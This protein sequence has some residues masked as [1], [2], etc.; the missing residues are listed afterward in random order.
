MASVD[1]KLDSEPTLNHRFLKQREALLNKK[2]ETPGLRMSKGLK[3]HLTMQEETV[4]GLRGPKAKF[5]EL[6][7]YEEKFGPAP[8]EKIK[9][10]TY[11]GA[12]IRGVDVIDDKVRLVFC[13]LFF[14]F[15]QI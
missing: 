15:S 3:E 10:I 5:M 8:P 1:K 6:S 9:T 12:S 13:F 11:K 2:I 4:S 14:F 7:V